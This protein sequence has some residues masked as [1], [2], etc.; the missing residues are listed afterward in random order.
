MTV[1]TITD[2]E[3]APKDYAS[4]QDVRSHQGA[5][6]AHVTTR[7]ALTLDAAGLDREPRLSVRVRTG[8]R[9]AVR[10][11]GGGHAAGRDGGVAA[12]GARAPRGIV[13]RGVPELRRLQRRRVRQLHREGRGGRRAAAPRARP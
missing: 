9:G 5:V 10:R 7:Y 1:T 12:A 3:L 4:D 11:T 6:L 13:R 2:A 8:R